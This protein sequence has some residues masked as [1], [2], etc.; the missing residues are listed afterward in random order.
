MYI[1]LLESQSTIKIIFTKVAMLLM[2]M[3]CF[4]KEISQLFESIH[5]NTGT[6]KEESEGPTWTSDLVTTEKS[7]T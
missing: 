5:D 3:L 7:C 6:V 2:Y 1:V 4:A